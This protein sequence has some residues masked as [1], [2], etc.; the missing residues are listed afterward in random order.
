MSLMTYNDLLKEQIK[1]LFSAETQLLSALPKM[2]A[3][4]NNPD[5]KKAFS[6]HLEETRTHVSRL[7]KA[8]VELGFPL[9]G[10]TCN[11]MKGLIEEAE[12]L[13]QTPGTADVKDAALIAA[14]QR[15]EHYEI[16]AY[17]TICQLLDLTDADESKSLLHDTLE[18]EKDADSKLTKLATG[19]LFSSGINK[20][21]K[22]R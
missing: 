13:I 3:A 8:G 2:V 10:V 17:G 5:L 22:N 9:S 6:D 12:E 19:K 21:A 18:E 16:A 4:A 7:E 14:A 1:D 11:A 20:D 15:V